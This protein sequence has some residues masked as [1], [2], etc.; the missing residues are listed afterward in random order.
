MTLPSLQR[1]CGVLLAAALF[2]PNFAAAQ[3]PDRP[4]K[5]I[6]TQGPGSSTDTHARLVGDGLAKRLGQAVVVDNIAGAA[7]TM[8]MATGARAAPDGYTLVLGN[9]GNVGIAPFTFRNLP[10]D[11][12]KDLVPVAHLTDNWQVLIASPKLGP[13]TLE[14]FIALAKASPGKLT[15]GSPG[16]GSHAHLAMEMLQAMAGIKLVHVPYRTTGQLTTDLIGGSVDVA[17]DNY[18]AVKGLA[19]QGR[20]RVLGVTSSGP[21]ASVPNVPPIAHTVPGYEAT[22]WFGLF[23]PA[24]T[25]PAVVRKLNAEINAVLVD[26]KVVQTMLAAGFEV[27]TSTPEQFAAFVGSAQKKWGDIVRAIGLAAK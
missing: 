27:K 17:F 4:L 13:V 12:N 1:L 10:Y 25:P 23:A 18:V 19:E 8:G 26:P 3:Y 15:Y 21:L 7:G 2:A 11:P 16:E 5:I 24:G 9:N 14:Q 6:A 22:G 20:L